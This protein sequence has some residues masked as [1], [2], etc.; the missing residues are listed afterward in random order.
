[1]ENP[2]FFIPLRLSDPY[3]SV[4]LPLG[5]VTACRPVGTKPLSEPMLE[6]YQLAIRNKLQVS[7][8]WNPYILVQKSISKWRLQNGGN[9]VLA[10]VG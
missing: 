4:N 5:Q 8:Y 6:Y 1:M 7:F 2:E 9:F 3:A 10:S